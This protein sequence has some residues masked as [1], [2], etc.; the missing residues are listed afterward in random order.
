MSGARILVVDDDPDIRQLVAELLGRAGHD[1]EQAPDGVP[2]ETVRG[3]G[4]RYKPP[5]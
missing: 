4:Y 3:F 2:I 1:V 5:A